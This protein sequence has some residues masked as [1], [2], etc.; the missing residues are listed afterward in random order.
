MQ[1]YVEL[2]IQHSLRC[3]PLEGSYMLNEYH[4]RRLQTTFPI[5]VPVG[6]GTSCSCRKRLPNSNKPERINLDLIRPR[7]GMSFGNA[8]SIASPSQYFRKFETLEIFTNRPIPQRSLARMVVSLHC[9]YQSQ[10]RRQSRKIPIVLRK[11]RA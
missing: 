3:P 2:R 7:S 5:G 8:S 4:W 9:G 11:W 10:L 6:T 1:L